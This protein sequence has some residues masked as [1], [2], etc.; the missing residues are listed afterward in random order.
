MP[1]DT[2]PFDVTHRVRNTCLCL[3]LQQATRAVAR[4]FDAALRSLNLTNGQ[5]SLLMSL[6]RP[7]AARIGDVSALLAMD[8]TTLT[9]NL[10]PLAR[11]GLVTISVDDA[12]KRSRRL[13]LTPAGHALLVAA[14]PVWET[15]H[16]AIEG[17]LIETEPDRLRSDLRMLS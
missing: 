11:R 6:N 12:D 4:R 5:F 2:L 8:R 7:E 1:D 17:L 10:K 9:A 13:A 14:V 15:Q 3:H 16:A